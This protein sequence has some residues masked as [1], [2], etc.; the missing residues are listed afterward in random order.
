MLNGRCIIL[1]LLDDSMWEGAHLYTYSRQDG[2]DCRRMT[3]F[4]TSRN[5]LK[6]HLIKGIMMQGS[7]SAPKILPI[8]IAR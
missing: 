8:P 5:K 3:D 7:G 6:P 4:S 2:S 1:I